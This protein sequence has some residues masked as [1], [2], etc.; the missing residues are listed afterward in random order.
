M[1]RIRRDRRRLGRFVGFVEMMANLSP[2][3]LLDQPP[4]SQLMQSPP[5]RSRQSDG[6]E[7][8]LTPAQQGSGRC[9]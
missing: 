2:V 8:S 7:N 4:S 1:Q 5:Y 6:T 3:L 9:S